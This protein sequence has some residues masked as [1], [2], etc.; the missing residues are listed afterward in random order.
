MCQPSPCRPPF[1]AATWAER[2][3]SR[4]LPMVLPSLACVCLAL[5]RSRTA[6]TRQHLRPRCP[7]R[8]AAV[9]LEE[10]D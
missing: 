8:G 5:S 3:G 1:G 6:A 10:T 4:V 9:W 7:D 2:L